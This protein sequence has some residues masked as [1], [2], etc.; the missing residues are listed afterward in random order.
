[1]MSSIITS[2]V[3]TGKILEIG[4]GDAHIINSLDSSKF[5]FTIVDFH[6]PKILPSNTVFINNNIDRLTC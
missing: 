2:K 5:S 3:K 4:A 1:M 6:K